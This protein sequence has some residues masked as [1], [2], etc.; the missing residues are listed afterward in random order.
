MRIGSWQWPDCIWEHW[1]IYDSSVKIISTGNPWGLPTRVRHECQGLS[2]WVFVQ[3]TMDI[4]VEKSK[5]GVDRIR[6]RSRAPVTLRLSQQP[7]KQ[8]KIDRHCNNN[9]V[10]IFIIALCF[11]FRHCKN[12]FLIVTLIFIITL[13]GWCWH[14][15]FIELKFKVLKDTIICPRSCD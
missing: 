12:A 3:V 10:I 4:Q 9:E 2:S 6:P 14:S 13:Q 15:Y 7:W 8:Y 11:Y 1:Y 5:T